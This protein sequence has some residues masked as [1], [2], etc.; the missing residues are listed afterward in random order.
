[1]KTE[2][3]TWEPPATLELFLEECRQ[4]AIIK[5]AYYQLLMTI[6]VKRGDNKTIN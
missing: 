1:M 5:E 2:T 4:K 3:K 6:Y